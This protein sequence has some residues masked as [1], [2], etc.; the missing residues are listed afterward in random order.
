MT[1]PKKTNKKN[2]RIKSKWKF[3][4]RNI[5]DLIKNIIKR[6]WRHRDK[7]MK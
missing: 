3:I 5:E 6:V 2:L 7:S 4:S 1:C